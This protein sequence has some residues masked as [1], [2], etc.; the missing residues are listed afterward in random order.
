MWWN[1]SFIF[2][3]IHDHEQSI[4][5]SYMKKSFLKLFLWLQVVGQELL[6]A[7]QYQSAVTVLEAALRIGSCSLKL[8]YV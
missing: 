6:A 7:G 3:F 1:H 5:L 4:H 2:T 8:R